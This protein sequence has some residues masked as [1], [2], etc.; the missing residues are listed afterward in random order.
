MA[1]ANSCRRVRI[2]T[3]SPMDRT[4][5]ASAATA[6]SRSCSARRWMSIGVAVSET[7]AMN[8]TRNGAT[9]A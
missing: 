1:I 8:G 7:T 2:S 9:S 4:D 3:R 5:A 6:G